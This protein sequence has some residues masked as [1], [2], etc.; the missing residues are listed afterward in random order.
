[1]EVGIPVSC[2]QHGVTGT[3]ALLGLGFD[4]LVGCF[5]CC[6]LVTGH[7]HS[8]DVGDGGCKSDKISR[9]IRLLEQGIKDEPTNCRWATP[10]EQA[11]NKTNNKI[12]F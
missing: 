10:K 7:V 2:H 4:V 11:N 1:M 3:V 12:N 8:Y 6:G 9:D 5:P